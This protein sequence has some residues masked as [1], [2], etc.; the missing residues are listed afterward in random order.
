MPR[1]RSFISKLSA[2]ERVLRA[3]EM[4]EKLAIRRAHT[5]AQKPIDAA[6]RGAIRDVE[7]V[8]HIAQEAY[9]E[10][11]RV[12]E[13]AVRPHQEAMWAALEPLQQ[14]REAALKEIE[15]KYAELLLQFTRE[16]EEAE[17]ASCDAK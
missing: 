6:Y 5:E 7:T 13:E 9:D 10:A 2:R 11:T 4:E 3:Q 12:H 16:L 15:E 1:S 17:A 14:Q 8:W